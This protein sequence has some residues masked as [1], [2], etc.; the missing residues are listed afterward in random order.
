MGSLC[1]SEYLNPGIFFLYQGLCVR[2]IKF[3]VR[4]YFIWFLVWNAFDM[5][6]SKG[7]HQISKLKLVFIFR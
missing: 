7:G 3:E 6:L 1:R 4:F 5:G 2:Q